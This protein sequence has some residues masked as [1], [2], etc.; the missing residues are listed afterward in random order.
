MLRDDRQIA[1]NQA[2]EACL[3][4]AH[5]HEHGA[6]RIGEDTA[7][8]RHLA[9]RRRQDAETLAGHLRR[10]GDLPTDPDPEYEVAAD[11]VSRV[12]AALAEDERHQVIARSRAAEDRLAEALQGVLKQDLPPDCQSDVER[13]LNAPAVLK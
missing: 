5:V 12:T 4:A 7:G 9:A 13:I 1:L 2:I 10:L 8:L 6:D 3:H 11:L